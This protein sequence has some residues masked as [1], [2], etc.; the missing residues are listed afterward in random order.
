MDAGTIRLTNALHRLLRNP[1]EFAL[2]AVGIV[3][4]RVGL[5]DERRVR[6]TTDLAWPRIL[7]G[8][9]RMSKS[10]ADVAMVGLVLGP[11][12]IAGIGFAAPFAFLAG[13]MGGGGIAGGTIS[14]VS[15]RFGADRRDELDLAIKQ[16][17]WVAVLLGIPFAALFWLVPEHLVGLI[18]SDADSIAYGAAYLQV[19]ALGIVFTNLNLVASR[20]LVGADDAHSPMIVRG[21]GALVNVA[22]NALFIFGLGMGIVGAALGTVLAEAFVTAWFAWGFLGREVPFAG[23]FPITVSPRGPYVDRELT[24]ELVEISTPIA[25]TGIAAS[26]GQFPLIAIVGLFGPEVVA[27]FVV[28]QRVRGLMDTP[29]WGFGL[30]SSSLVG[31]ELGHGDELEAEA[32]GWDILRFS[33]VVYFLL[34]AA[35]F[36]FAEQVGRVFVSDPTILPLV[37]VFVQIAAVSV[38][39]NSVSGAATGPLIASGDTRWP[40][41][42]RVLGLYAV[43][44]PVAYLGAVTPLGIAALYF[45]LIL[46]TMVPALVVL[47][48]FNGGRW[49]VVSRS[50]GTAQSAD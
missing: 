5:V 31:Q 16:S 38:L 25:F 22:L 27:A 29:G 20:A 7:T 45:A 30:A 4:A 21:G 43:A 18:G 35:T 42:G 12:A 37:A 2:L 32:Y 33:F 11:A 1:I 44:I 17:V 26:A 41:Y 39:W 13:A 46:E 28:A 34:A 19:A 50:Y 15:R 24:R 48:R 36:V 14:L 8:L 40:F 49:K 3:L 10:A 47:S 23:R 9:A 6:R